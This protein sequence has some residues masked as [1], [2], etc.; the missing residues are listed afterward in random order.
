MIRAQERNASA[1]RR[2]YLPA[3]FALFKEARA[4]LGII[5][6]P[7]GSALQFSLAGFV[8]HRKHHGEVF[9]RLS[10]RLR[11]RDVCLR[12]ARRARARPCVLHARGACAL[13]VPAVRAMTDQE[14]LIA[15]RSTASERRLSNDITECFRGDYSTRI[16][17]PLSRPPEP[18]LSGIDLSRRS[19]LQFRRGDRCEAPTTRRRGRVSDAARPNESLSRASGPGAPRRCARS[20]G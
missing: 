10:R 5:D 7:R 8:Y 18:L 19:A 9:K 15:S 11:A 13:R 14:K 16:F 2:G 4:S 6:L 12:C 17:S 3:L 20:G 1:P